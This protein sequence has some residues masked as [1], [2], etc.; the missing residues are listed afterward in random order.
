MCP[1]QIENRV[2][3]LRDALGDRIRQKTLETLLGVFEGHTGHVK[4]LDDCELGFPSQFSQKKCGA[5]S[6][7][8]CIEVEL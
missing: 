2:N 1:L 7:D 6:V 4:T 3:E 5:W 8:L